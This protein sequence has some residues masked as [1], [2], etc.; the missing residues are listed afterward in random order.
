MKNLLPLA[1][2]LLL[3]ACAESPTDDRLE[4]AVKATIRQ[5]PALL[6]DSL[7][8]RSESGVVYVRGLVATQVEFVEVDQM[9][10]STPGV[11]KFVNMT[12][13]DNTRF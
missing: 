10:K 9:L 3:T 4:E 12:T 1:A 2:L 7:S 5:H 11:T 6:A 13:I 8:V